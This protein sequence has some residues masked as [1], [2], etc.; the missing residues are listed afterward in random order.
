MTTH[1]CKWDEDFLY[2]KYLCIDTF[3]RFSKGIA[4]I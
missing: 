1:N 4:Q 3:N 2:N